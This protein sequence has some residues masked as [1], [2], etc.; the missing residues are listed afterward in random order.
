MQL[1]WELCDIPKCCEWPHYQGWTLLHLWGKV[2]KSVC[3]SL[4]VLFMQRGIHLPLPPLAHVPPPL[5]TMTEVGQLHV[6][7]KSSFPFPLRCLVYRNRHQQFNHRVLSVATCGQRVN[8]SLSRPTFRMFGGRESDITEQPWQT[9]INAYQAR[10]K[11]HIYRC[12]G[13]LIDSCWV[14]SAA[15]CFDDK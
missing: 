2:I 1:T 7:W 10:H 3:S 12:G 13:V 4:S 11:K 9:V 6:H 5:T 15:H 14:L 8:N